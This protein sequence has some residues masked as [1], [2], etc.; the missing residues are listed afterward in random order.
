M[1]TK[2]TPRESFWRGHWAAIDGSAI[3]TPND[4]ADA[5]ARGDERG[6]AALAEAMRCKTYRERWAWIGW[7]FAHLS[8]FACESV[9]DLP[10]TTG[11]ALA[12]SAHDA[13]WQESDQ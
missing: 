3:A 10:K 6:A 4:D 11:I 13:A 7:Y 1:S 8:E 5:Y 9:Q 12:R 2:H